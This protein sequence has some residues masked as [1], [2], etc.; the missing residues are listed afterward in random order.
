MFFFTLIRLDN[1]IR[2]YLLCLLWNVYSK[3]SLVG[4]DNLIKLTAQA[5]TIGAG[6]ACAFSGVSSSTGLLGIRGGGRRTTA[7]VLVNMHLELKD[8]VDIHR[9]TVVN[10]AHAT[11]GKADPFI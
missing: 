7:E 11:G 9:D 3:I 10:A 6:D 4:M 1:V 5:A 8:K 2:H